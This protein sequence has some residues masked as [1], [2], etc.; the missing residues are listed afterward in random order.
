VI[1]ELKDQS[2][3]QWQNEWVQNTKGVVSKS[4]FPKIVDSM[5]LTIN[6]TPNFTTMVTGHGYTVLKHICINSKSF[7]TQCAPVNKMNNQLTISYMT[8]A[9]SHDHD[10]DKL[11]A[12][13]IRPDSWPVSKVKLGAKYYKNFKDFTDNILLNKE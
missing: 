13:V 5:K 2:L 11:K 9:N 1:S 12:A 4:F 3:K 7:K 8:T 6:A 10:R